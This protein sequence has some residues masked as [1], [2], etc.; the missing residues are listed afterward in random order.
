MFRAKPA[1]VPSCA[2]AQP[3][4]LAGGAQP[5]AGEGERAWVGGSC[6]CPLQHLLPACSRSM[7][8]KEGGPSR[9]RRQWWQRETNGNRHRY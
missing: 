9:R 4:W 6:D 7:A 5:L 1:L 2:P 8:S 3:P